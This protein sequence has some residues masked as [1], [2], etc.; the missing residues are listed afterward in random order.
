[1][2]RLG[3]NSKSCIL[4][5]IHSPTP[6]DIRKDYLHNANLANRFSLGQMQSYI[7]SLQ[8]QNKWWVLREGLTVDQLVLVGD[9]EVVACRGVYRLERFHCLYPQNRKGKEIISRATVAVL[10][11]NAVVRK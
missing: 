4:K 11:K 5:N 6:M 8:N 7:S 1:V 9:A 10:A 2:I 3:K